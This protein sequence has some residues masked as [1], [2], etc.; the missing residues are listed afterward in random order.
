[1]LPFVRMLN[2]GNKAPSL[3]EITKILV[4]YTSSRPAFMVLYDDNRLYGIGGGT[5][6]N[7]IYGDG[8]PTEQKLEWT[9]I[10]D[11]VQDV[12]CTNTSFV[13]IKTMDG[14]LLYTGRRS[15]QT[16]NTS[17]TEVVTSYTDCTP[18]IESGIG[19]G[20]LNQITSVHA[21]VYALYILMNNG[22]LY[23]SGFNN[24][25]Q[26]ATGN[27]LALTTFS[28]LTSDVQKVEFVNSSVLILK[29]DLSVWVSGSNSF[30]QLGIGHPDTRINVLTQVPL[31][32]PGLSVFDIGLTESAFTILYSDGTGKTH[33]YAAGSQNAGNLGNGVN[34]S[35]NIRVFTEIATTENF[36]GLLSYYTSNTGYVALSPSNAYGCGANASGRLSTGVNGNELNLIPFGNGT[37]NDM[38]SVFNI[39]STSNITSAYITTSGKLRYS[40]RGPDGVYKYSYTEFDLP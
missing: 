33:L 24:Q 26:L 20:N 36:I 14:K 23:R 19:T 22:D 39:F 9:L 40:G 6:D 31:P 3:P 5:V 12:W 4:P 35:V 32:D 10:R 8:K 34:S 1:M 16:G 18:F 27:Y 21:G 13:I 11:D 17:S 30:G 38:K 15:F 7:Y 2:Y 29:N 28:K 37:V 25:G